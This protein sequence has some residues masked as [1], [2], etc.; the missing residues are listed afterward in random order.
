ML[1]RPGRS[2]GLQIARRLGLPQQ[3]LE[4][5]ERLTPEAMRT[6]EATLKDLETR[7]AALREREDAAA[8]REGE[9]EAERVRLARDR[10]DLERRLEAVRAR[11]VELERAGR[12]QAR[13]FL[14]EARRRVEEALGVARAAVSEAT[15]KEARRLVEEGV[16]EEAEALA[17]LE[18]Q[19]REKGWTIRLGKKG[20]T[21]K[22]KRETGTAA[23]SGTPGDSSA[24]DLSL[25][26]L[27]VSLE[28]ASSEIDL[29]GMRA[30]DAEAAVLAALDDAVVADLPSLRIIHGKGT[31][32]LRARVRE[33]LQGDGRV[34]AFRPAPPTEGGAGVTIAELGS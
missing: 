27:P 26:P 8:R 14:L 11:E 13:R 6:L 32:A 5:A 15:A 1:G 20:E 21:G 12:E 2:Y 4:A 18:A 33:V 24:G 30:D 31:G 22:R 10:S 34:Q 23:G 25:F 17:K 28:R 29:R 16:Q 9:G 19:A 7:E 3:V